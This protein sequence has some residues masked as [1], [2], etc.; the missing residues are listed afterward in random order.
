MSAPRSFLRRAALLAALV[1]LVLPAA[2]L[3]GG[4]QSGTYKQTN[5]VSDIPGVANITDPD[6]KNPW[7]L[8]AGPQTP[9]WVAD[10]GTDKATIYP[11]GTQQTLISKAPLVVDIDGGAPTGE[12]YNPTDGFALGSTGPALFLFSSEAGRITAWNKAAGTT[13]QTVFT[14]PDGAIYKGLTLVSRKQGPF[15]YAS[16]FHNGKVDVFDSSF[17]PVH[18]PG[19]FTDPNLPA[20]FA[21]FGIQELDGFVVVTY[22]MQDADREDDVK[23]A[24]LGYVDVYTPGGKLVKRLI[25]QGELNAPWGLV[26]APSGF[27]KFSHALLV[28]NFGDGRINAYD[29]HSGNFLGSLETKFGP[30]AIDGLWGL[31]FGNGVTGSP[32]TLL[33]SAGINDENN[34]LLGAIKARRH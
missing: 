25:S 22:A 5:L 10:N 6:L 1:A 7:G 9:L 20:G 26:L 3:A 4:K 33:F 16:D 31:R 27:G 32:H 29:P 19:A 34:G 12:V 8:A 23:G 13:A 2:A 24:G 11:G 18:M 14:S 30:I 21:P 17:A 15:L 28:G